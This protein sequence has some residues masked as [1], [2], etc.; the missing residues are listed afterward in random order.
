[1]YLEEIHLSLN[2]DCSRLFSRLGKPSPRAC[3]KGFLQFILPK[4]VAFKSF[5]SLLFSFHASVEKRTDRSP[6]FHTHST[7][8]LTSTHFWAGV[9]SQHQLFLSDFSDGNFKGRQDSLK[10]PHSIH[11]GPTLLPQVLKA[12][13]NPSLLAHNILICLPI[14]STLYK[15]N[16]FNNFRNKDFIC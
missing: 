7:E 15:R 6:P 9:S 8:T 13:F 12:Q 4:K 11:V 1:M 3:G 16:K 10:P 14:C 2:Q 5:L